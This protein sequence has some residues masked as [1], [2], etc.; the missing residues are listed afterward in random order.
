MH[1][2]GYEA[3]KQKM[4]SVKRKGKVNF[5]INE[6]INVNIELTHFYSSKPGCVCLPTCLAYSSARLSLVK[7][8]WVILARAICYWPPI[9]A[10]FGIP[11]LAKRIK[12]ALESN[13]CRSKTKTFEKFHFALFFDM[14]I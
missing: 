13:E 6:L 14:K 7:R 1:D 5:K 3:G 8:P 4:C 10:A 2:L 9:F 12:V 11:A